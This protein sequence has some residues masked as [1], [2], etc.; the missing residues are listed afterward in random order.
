MSMR[1]RYGFTWAINKAKIKERGQV[2]GDSALAVIT[3]AEDYL[4]RYIDLQACIGLMR[5]LQ[6]QLEGSSG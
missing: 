3:R 1:R 6:G 4:E 5:S 2:E